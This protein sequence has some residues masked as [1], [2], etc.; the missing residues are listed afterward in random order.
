MTIQILEKKF[1]VST[2][3]IRYKIW[4]DDYDELLDW[5]NNFMHSYGLGYAG[6]CSDAKELEYEDGYNMTASHWTSCD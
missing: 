3:S 5:K 1:V 4:G 2:K 6:E